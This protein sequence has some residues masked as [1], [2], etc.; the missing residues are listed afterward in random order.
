M[1]ED[2][3]GAEMEA[4]SCVSPSDSRVLN[5]ACQR[6]Y[7][8]EDVNYCVLLRDGRAGCADDSERRIEAMVGWV[9]LDPLERDRFLRWCSRR[10][11]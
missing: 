9:C 4:Q 5:L 11:E 2:K 7:G 6:G 1:S 10:V 8:P 3:E